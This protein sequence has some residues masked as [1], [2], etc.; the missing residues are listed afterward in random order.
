VLFFVL[1]CS[2]CAALGYNPGREARV[3][4]FQSEDWTNDDTSNL[5]AY[6]NF[7][8]KPYRLP[9]TWTSKSKPDIK[10]SIL[11][12]E[13]YLRFGLCAKDVT[14]SKTNLKTG[15]SAEVVFLAWQDH[16][17]DKYGNRHPGS[18]YVLYIN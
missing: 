12:I 9:Y 10:Y 16:Y 8:N 15:E 17:T 3:A 18:G 5:S 6:V 7:A 13:E 14:I 2:G 4:F 11:K 1:F